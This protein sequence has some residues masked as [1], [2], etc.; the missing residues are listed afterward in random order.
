MAL[1]IGPLLLGRP[2]TLDVA[3]S[4][5]DATGYGVEPVPIET[6]SGRIIYKRR[7]EELMERSAPVRAELLAA[8]DAFLDEAFGPERVAEACARPGD[9][10]YATATPGGKPWR[11]SRIPRPEIG[12]TRVRDQPRVGRRRAAKAGAR[13]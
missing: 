7:Q 5:Y 3:A 2:R 1:H 6:A 13:E 4:P 10:R 12:Q 11:H 9:E 8:F